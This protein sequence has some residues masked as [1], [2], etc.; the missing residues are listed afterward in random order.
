MLNLDKLTTNYLEFCKYQKNLNEK[1]LKA[2][3]IDLNQFT[4][5]MKDT[6]GELSKS[7]VSN[8][9]TN[10]HKTYKPKTVKR[11]I[12]CLK[13]FINYLEYDEII[14]KNP[15]CMNMPHILDAYNFKE[16]QKEQFYL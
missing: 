15:G 9:I 8:Y 13:A 6:D 5:F 12:A 4:Y 11:K 1:S 16:L 10:L 14:E 7:N 2:Y 3:K